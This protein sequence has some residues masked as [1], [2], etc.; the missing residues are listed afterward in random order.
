MSYEDKGT[1]IALLLK[2]HGLTAH[3][4]NREA[5]IGKEEA[6]SGKWGHKALFVTACY[7]L[8][9]NVTPALLTCRAAPYQGMDKAPGI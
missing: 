2:V 6:L 5:R 3:G 7:I 8:H 9:C 4:Y 1:N